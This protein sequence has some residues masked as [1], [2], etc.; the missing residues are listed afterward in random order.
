MAHED[1]LLQALCVRIQELEGSPVSE[2]CQKD[3]EV[4][5]PGGPRRQPH[6][7]PDRDLKVWAGFAGM[8][9]WRVHLISCVM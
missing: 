1:C 3:G 6:P 7:L 5:C 9:E 2:Q 8:W 4:F